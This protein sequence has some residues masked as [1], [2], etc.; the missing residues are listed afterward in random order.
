MNK[1]I[2]W[3]LIV[4]GGLIVLVIAALLIIPM[5]VDIQKYK[6]EL[7]KR[8]A[9]ATGRPFTLG[10][11]LSLSLFPWAGVSL[12]DLH[13]GNPPGFKEKDFLFVKSFEVRVKLLPLISKEIQ[14]KR[15]IL[16]GPRIVLEKRKDGRGNWEGLGKPPKEKAKPTEGKPSEGLPIKSLVVGEFAI[17]DGSALLIDHKKGERQEISDVALRL[18]DISLDRPVHITLSALLDGKPLS[19]EGDL[20]P[21]GKDPGKG[22]IPLDLSIKALKQLDMVLKGKLT[23]P[24]SRMQFDLELNVSPFSPRKLLTSL[25]KKFPIST[26]DPK[27][28]T[29]VAL[30][31]KVKGDPKSISV[32]DG[33]LDLDQ[34]KLTFS[35]KAK[36]FSK[37]DVAFNLNLDSMDLDRY[38]PPPSKKKADEE[39]KK[40]K[41]PTPDQ[42]KTDYTPLRRLILDGTIRAGKLK[43]HDLK[44]QDLSMKLTGKNGLFNLDPLALKLYKGDMSIKGIFDVRKDIPKS[45]MELQAKGI[46][47]G[48]LLKDLLKKDF[49]EGTAQSK[50]AISMAGDDAEKIKSTLNGKGDFLFKDGAIVGI[51]LAGMVRNIKSTFGLA[52]KD[53]K[54]PRTDFSELHSPFTITN[55]VFNTSK[56]SMSSPLIRVLAAGK[57]DLVKEDL[58]FRVEPKFVATLKGQDDTEQRAG[59]TVP[60]LVTGSFNSPKF[61]PDLKGMMKKALGDPSKL[62]EIL[63]SPGSKEIGESAPKEEKIKGLLKSLPF[64]R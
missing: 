54:K 37:P 29:R 5:F 41:A 7:E 20:G 56:T 13:L 58:D 60:V 33:A 64:K 38:L 49:L 55:G 23:D 2:K 18:D 9:E 12:S 1:A 19:L 17:T 31:A 30:K 28:L 39:K 48:P 62:K 63:K 40:A 32:S 27:A 45:K 34:S 10:G 57:A 8:V 43:A 35:V 14:V 22:T 47:S 6:P 61:R 4:G 15:F 21:L 51:D 52:E 44:I 59:I 46:Q 42:K 24:A 50:V 16:E 26:A 11:D 25:G 3:I 53:K 36:D